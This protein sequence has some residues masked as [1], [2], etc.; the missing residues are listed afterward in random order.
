MEVSNNRSP[1]MKLFQALDTEDTN[2]IRRGS[3]SV[4]GVNGRDAFLASVSAAGAGT[5]AG[6]ISG[7]AQIT[8]GVGRIAGE[9][10][11]TAVAGEAADSAKAY[12]SGLKSIAAGFSAFIPVVGTF[13]NLPLAVMDGAQA[14]VA[15][16]R[17]E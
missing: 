6:M 16:L 12:A 17:G 4:A 13:V 3:S 15:A 9:L 7:S 1:F 14:G 11:G 2:S 5:I 10:F 8:I